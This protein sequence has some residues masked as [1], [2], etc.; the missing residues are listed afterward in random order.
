MPIETLMLGLIGTTKNGT[1]KTEIHF[2][3]KEKFLE[4]HQESGYV[5]ASLPVDTA[6]DLSLHDHRWRVAIAL[7]NLHVDTGKIIA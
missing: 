5:I 4:L 2:Q 6:R 1:T 3:P 7:Y